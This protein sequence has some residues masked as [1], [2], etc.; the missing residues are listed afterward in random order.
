MRP[1]SDICLKRLE[2]GTSPT[3]ILDESGEQRFTSSLVSVDDQQGG[4]GNRWQET[5]PPPPPLR[6]LKIKIR[7]SIWLKFVNTLNAVLHI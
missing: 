7:T 1:P 6:C 4:P 5:A 3:L 2:Q